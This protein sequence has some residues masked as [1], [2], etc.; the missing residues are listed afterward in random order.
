[1]LEKWVEDHAL[2]YNGIHLYTNK[3]S[4]EFHLDEDV[5][6]HWSP[7]HFEHVIQLRQ[8]ALEHLRQLWADF[9]FVCTYGINYCML[10]VF[11]F[12]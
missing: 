10:I 11:T 6:T 2:E 1:M 7:M 12:K 8:Q 3:T 9:V 5:S 4:G